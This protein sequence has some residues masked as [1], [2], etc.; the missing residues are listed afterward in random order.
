MGSSFHEY[1]GV[2]WLSVTQSDH[3]GSTD[4]IMFGRLEDT[5]H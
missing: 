3:K 1:A 4:R 2:I 5:A